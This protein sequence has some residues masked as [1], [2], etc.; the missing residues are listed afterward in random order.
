MYEIF[1]NVKDNQEIFEAYS[2]L[3][4]YKVFDLNNGGGICYIFFTS[5]GLFFPT[6]LFEFQHEVVEKNKFEW[7]NIG[8]EKRIQEKAAKYIFV[9]DIYKNFCIEGISAVCNSHYKVAEKLKTLTKGYKVVTVGSS[10][11]GFMAVLFGCLLNA[12]AIYAFSPQISL[13]IYNKYHPIKYFEKYRTTQPFMDL[14]QLVNEYRGNMYFFY[15]NACDEDIAQYE[16]IEEFEKVRFFSING[17]VHGAPLY[18]ISIREILCMPYLE[19][20]NLFYKYKNKRISPA[21]FLLTTNGFI[22]GMPY[23]C[24]RAIKKSIRKIRTILNGKKS[25]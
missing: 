25:H 10:A 19:L 9:R 18:G 4:N 8:S 16:Y 12:E 23:I 24:G 6:T 21:R 7:V 5:H 15:A 14:K 17:K 1:E 3:P 13:E 22:E 2:N 20:D 11:G